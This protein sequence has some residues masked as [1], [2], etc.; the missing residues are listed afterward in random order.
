MRKQVA[1]HKATVYGTAKIIDERK[2][3]EAEIY[4]YQKQMQKTHQMLKA[5]QMK[6]AQLREDQDFTELLKQYQQRMGHQRRQLSP[7]VLKRSPKPKRAS[8][9]KIETASEQRHRLQYE[10]NLREF[11]AKYQGAPKGGRGTMGV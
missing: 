9:K 7:F 5:K 2:K 4:E 3:A 1:K 6:E 8:V 10:A 11:E